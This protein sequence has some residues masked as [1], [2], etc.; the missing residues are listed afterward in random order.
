MA[1]VSPSTRLPALRAVL[2][3]GAIEDNIGIT[4]AVIGG[5]MF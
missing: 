3:D 2:E 4:G 1:E 5:G